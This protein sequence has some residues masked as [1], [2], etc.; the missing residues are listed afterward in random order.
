[1]SKAEGAW[2]QHMSRALPEGCGMGVEEGA[3][4]AAVDS[5]GDGLRNS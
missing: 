1:M 5:L 2:H 4:V 3:G